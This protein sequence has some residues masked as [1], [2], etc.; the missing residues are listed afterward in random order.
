MLIFTNKN[1]FETDANL[2]VNTVNTVGVMGKGIAL[3]F[4]NRFPN[5]FKFYKKLCDNNEFKIG[6]ILIFNEN[7]KLILNFPTKKHW[8]N[9]SEYEWIEKGLN[10]LRKILLNRNKLFFDDK[11]A[12]PKLGC[13]NGNLDWELVKPL[14]IKYLNDIDMIIYVCEK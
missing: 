7:N 13:S 1:L 14:I 3:E 4:K 2:L 8:K 6:D 12:I 9:N 10:S 5:N 11:I